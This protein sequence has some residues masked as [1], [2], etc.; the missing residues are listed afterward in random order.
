MISRNQDK[1]RREVFH[2]NVKEDGMGK[3]MLCADCG[4]RINVG[5]DAWEADH[6]IRLVLSKND[7]AYSNG[8]VLCKVCHRHKTSQDIKDNAKGKRSHDKHFGIT[9]KRGWR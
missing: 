6:T 2:A 3:Y 8:Q 5:R 1:F 9:R 7:D 4:I